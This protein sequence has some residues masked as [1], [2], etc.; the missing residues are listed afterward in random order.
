VLAPLLLP[1]DQ[2]VLD[3]D[4]C[5]WLGDDAIAGSVAA[6]EALRGA[7]KSVAFATND[8]RHPTEETVAKLWRL[9]V[10]ASLADVVTVGGAVQHLL[11]DTRHGRSAFVIGTQS[12][13]DHVSAAGLTVLNGT[14]R[15]ATAEVVVLGGTDDLT[16]EDL[17]Q[18][19]LALRAGADFLATGRDPT[20]P[21]PDGLWP[22]TGA[23]LAAVE[24]ASG[25]TAEIVGKPQPQL[26]LT[27]IDRLGEG[28]TLVV[29]DRLDADV[30]GAA[31]AGLDAAL[32]LSGGTSAAEADAATTGPRP[33]AVAA[34][35]AALVNGA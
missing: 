35:L 20:Y 27:A 4:G 6:I 1:Y 24:I 19:T 12:L 23:I 33:V 17:K 21:M 13:R 29:G 34:N 30:A 26:F 16:F 11:A 10:Q 28:R 22:G 8:P 3:L 2:V 7:G 31:A 18:A 9:G 32:V 25:R 14:D 15:A 5:V